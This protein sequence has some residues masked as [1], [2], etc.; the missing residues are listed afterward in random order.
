MKTMKWLM[1][2]TFA[3]AFV[4]MDAHASIPA[5]DGTYY[6]CYLKGFRT[7]R[8]IDNATQHC[9]SRIETQ[10]TWTKNGSG[11]AGPMG[12]TGPVGPTGPAGLPGQNGAPG[13]VNAY[14]T[15]GP[16]STVV[17]L[18]PPGAT[19]LAS[20]TLDPGSYFVSAKAVIAVTRTATDP[21]T[22]ALCILG[23]TTNNTI[24]DVA[25]SNGSDNIVTLS[26]SVA[27]TV[28]SGDPPLA[29][30]CGATSGGSAL[31]FVLTALP[32]ATITR[33]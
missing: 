15:G 7:L 27:V 11:P 5:P 28:A 33:Q 1:A 25:W 9:L 2:P 13:V 20:L 18:P 10:V 14:A 30:I 29:W 8:V 22:D 19:Q 32:V 24:L 31:Y 4:A 6:G 3:L 17:D 26:T 21:P 23:N 16:N 12:P